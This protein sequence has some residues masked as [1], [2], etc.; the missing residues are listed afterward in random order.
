MTPGETLRRELLD[1]IPDPLTRQRVERVL[2][3]YGGQVVYL[4]QAD[5]AARER[6]AQVLLT[7]GMPHADAVKAY[8]ARCG[9]DES[10]ARKAL[11]K[12][13]VSGAT[14]GAV[15]STRVHS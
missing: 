8:A 6:T 7:S 15:E 3:R 4:R 11:R 14:V 10:T 2:A 13:R 9:V 5:S 1:A 12:L